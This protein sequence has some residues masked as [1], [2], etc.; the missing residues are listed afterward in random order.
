MTTLVLSIEEADQSLAD[1]VRRMRDNGLAVV[2]KDDEGP[3]AYVTL[4]WRLK[5]CNGNGHSDERE[6]PSAEF[7]Q[8]Q[9]GPR[10]GIDKRTGFPVVNG[11]VG[12]RRVTA[13]EIYEYLR[14]DFP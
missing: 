8:P 2:I 5:D 13:E 7:Q 4:A 14:R 6:D 12:Q 10:Y 11:R 3:L 9:V 1:L